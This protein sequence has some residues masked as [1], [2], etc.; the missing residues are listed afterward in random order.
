V[1]ATFYESY[2]STAATVIPLFMFLIVFETR[3]LNVRPNV[4]RRLY[5]L[6]MELIPMPLLVVLFVFAEWTCFVALR[7]G[8][9]PAHW[10]RELLRLAIDFQLVAILLMG[11]LVVLSPITG[12]H[13]WFPAMRERGKKDDAS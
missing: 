3:A 6:V 13:T 4:G 1:L 11:L 9:D 7:D 12:R 2:Y 10:R 5:T 8:R